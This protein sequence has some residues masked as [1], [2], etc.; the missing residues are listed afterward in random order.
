MRL[1]SLAVPLALCA[2]L[3]ACSDEPE[4]RRQLPPRAA[5]LQGAPRYPDAL[6]LDTTGTEEAE[7]R[8]WQAA[9]PFDTVAA[10]FRRELPRAQW[11]VLNDRGDSTVLDLYARRDSFSLWVHV[12]PRTDQ[13]ALIRMVGARSATKA[14]R[15]VPNR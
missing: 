9:A 8:V 2:A 4:P 10:F 13:N 6:L 14:D 1:S 11:Q 3:A 5:V 12:E 15:P 7:L